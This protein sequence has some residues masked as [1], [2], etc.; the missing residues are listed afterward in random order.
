MKISLKF[1]DIALVF[2]LILEKKLKRERGLISL[3]LTLSYTPI[4][5]SPINFPTPSL[6]YPSHQMLLTSHLLSNLRTHLT[7]QQLI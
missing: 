2:F 1:Y 7:I 3:F 5:H 6:T 4:P